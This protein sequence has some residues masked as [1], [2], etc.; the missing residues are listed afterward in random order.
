MR[1]ASRGSVCAV[2]S[3]PTTAFADLVRE[4]PTATQ[5]VLLAAAADD[6]QSLAEAVRA[7]AI[8]LGVSI[9]ETLA[10]CM[11]AVQR[12][13]VEGDTASLRFR[14]EVVRSAIYQAAS[15]ERRRDLHLAFTQVLAGVPARRAWHRAAATLE[16]DEALAEELEVAATTARGHGRLHE[17]LASMDRAARVSELPSATGGTAPAGRRDGF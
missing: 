2:A 13:L 4:L 17:A 1:E 15:L 9:E 11:P 10:A 14:S 6:P 16:P 7:A 8:T 12:R 3:G 5:E